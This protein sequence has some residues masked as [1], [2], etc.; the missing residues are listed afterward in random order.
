MRPLEY[1]NDPD[2]SAVFFRRTIKNLEG[3]GGLWPEGKK[4]YNPFGCKVR[5]VAKEFV[6][7]SGAKIA[8]TYLENDNQVELNHQGLICS[9]SIQ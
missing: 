6:F 1:I 7:D 3:A 9:P 2:F 5:E 4:L 8:M